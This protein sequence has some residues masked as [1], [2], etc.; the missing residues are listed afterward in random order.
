MIY[1]VTVTREGTL[2]VAIVHDDTGK[3]GP[4]GTD[5]ERFADLDLEV[6][7]IISLLADCEPGDFD[8]RWQY[9]FG[10]HDVTGLI[11]DLQGSRTAREQADRKWQS[12]RDELLSVLLSAGL[13][14]TAIGDMLGISHQRVHQLARQA[15]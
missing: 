14:Q 8:L 5:T 6:R 1:D 12:S 13:P 4:T 3:L 15:G 11:E 7:D 10:G 9:V 2:W